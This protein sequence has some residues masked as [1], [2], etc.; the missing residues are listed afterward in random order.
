MLASLVAVIFALSVYTV[1]ATPHTG[2]Y[3]HFLRVDGC[4]HAANDPNV[5]CGAPNKTTHDRPYKFNGPQAAPKQSPLVKRYDTKLPPYQ[6]GRIGGIGPVCKKYDSN[7]DLAVCLWNGPDSKKHTPESSGWLN[8][9]KTSNCG[10]RVYV[11]RKT[12][13]GN[14]QF[15]QIVEGCDFPTKNFTIGCAQ[16]GLS[17][18][19]FRALKA[20]PQ[21]EDQGFLNT[22]LIWDYD[23]FSGQHT[24][25]APV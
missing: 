3:N 8:E 6:I 9:A 11:M 23:S 15:A 14:T 18:A 22:P 16:I 20:T 25:Q 17:N 21:E 10:K 19:L 24:Q 13:V 12:D 2:C 5:R 1:G 7:R 4:V